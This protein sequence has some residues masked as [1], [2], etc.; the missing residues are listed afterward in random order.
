MS[1]RRHK[2]KLRKQ[3]CIG[4]S[5]V[6][7]TPELRPPSHLPTPMD[8]TNYQTYIDER[9]ILVEAEQKSSDEFDKGI[10][11]LSS[12]ALGLS[13]V[14]LEKIAPSPAVE[15]LPYLT[16][17]WTFLILSVLSVLASFRTSVHA[18]Q[19]QRSILEADFFGSGAP[20]ITT[21]PIV[22]SLL[23]PLFRKSDWHY[24]KWTRLTMFLNW[25]S[26]FTF[27]L[28]TCFLA[29][30]SFQNVWGTSV[31]KPQ[32]EQ[33]EKP[34]SKHRPSNANKLDEGTVPANSPFRDI[35]GNVPARPPVQRPIQPPEGG[36]Q[37]PTKPTEGKKNSTN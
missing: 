12:G 11:T 5:P 28:G 33:M 26:I 36:I 19:D 29:W 23:N 14:F 22:A 6:D 30:F 24:N 17:A 7:Q 18:Y 27:I 13:L 35:L 25:C 4:V 10:L 34:M 1:K 37:K 15:T 2:P 16:L 3:S 9:K 20:E 32:S 8:D 31:N 21:P